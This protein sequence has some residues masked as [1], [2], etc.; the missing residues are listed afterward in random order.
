MT[1]MSTPATLLDAAGL[2]AAIA[3]ID[4]SHC[5]ATV[6]GYGYVGKEHVKA[7]QKLG[8]RRIRVCTRSAE[9]AAPL[10]GEPGIE[11]L[12]G[13]FEHLAITPEQDELVIIGTPTARLVEAARKLC[14]LG[15]RRLLIEKPVALHPDVIER[16]AEYL[17]RQGVEAAVAYNRV[18]YPALHE[19]RARAAAEGGVTSCVYT[20]TEMIKPNW[21][22]TFPPEELARWGIANSLHVMSMAH[23]LI[24]LPREY[25]AHRARNGRI[26][27]HPAG[28]V[29]VGAGVSERGI[30]FSYHADWGSTGR[31]SVEIHTPVS[32]Y[33]LRPLEEV[34]RRTAPLAEWEKLPLDVF[35]PDVK[36]G[37]AEEAA[38]ML[39]PVLRTKIPL[40][41]L[42]QAAALTRFGERVFGYDRKPGQNNG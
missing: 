19:I 21:Q 8:V 12:T 42:S 23:G 10:R 4:C 17:D 27:W 15:F 20:F 2:A 36:P 25:H 6:V 13:G 16:L 18:A 31:W 3:N 38:A 35:A 5:S 22:E 14:E 40:F 30:P 24:G 29:F 34:R 41:S 33:L 28:D 1:S 7:L 39:H 32:S 9:R 26:A 37:F 11:V